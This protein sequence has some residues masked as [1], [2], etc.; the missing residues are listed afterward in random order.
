MTVDLLIYKMGFISLIVSVFKRQAMFAAI[1][2]CVSYMVDQ[3]TFVAHPTWIELEFR[4]T[5]LAAKDF[6]IM[7]MLFT[8][9]K[10]PEITLGVIFAVSSLFHQCMLVEIQNQILTLKHMRTSFM[11][12]V[13]AMQL[14]TVILILIT[15]STNNGGKR[16]KHYLS[17]VDRS[18]YNLFHTPA[19]KVKS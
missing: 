8:R 18:F 14:A 19:Y 12:V 5:A 13:A 4:Y 16:A 15:G 1:L 2:L 9:L 3:Y 17:V 10:T 11:E 6:I 7:I